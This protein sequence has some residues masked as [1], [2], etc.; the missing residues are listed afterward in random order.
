MSLAL[1]LVVVAVVV[2]VCTTYSV[3]R[4]LSLNLRLRVLDA[5]ASLP[6]VLT[7]PWLDA[8]R[9]RARLQSGCAGCGGAATPGAAARRN[10]TTGALRR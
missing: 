7:A 2:A 1:Q 10:R 5:L 4:L 9:A 8:L 3:W 6:R